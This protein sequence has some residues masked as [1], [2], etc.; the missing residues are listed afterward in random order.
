MTGSDP[1]KRPPYHHGDLHHALVQAGTELAR[2]GGP[3][4]IVLREAA[5]RVGV[6]PNAAYRHFSALPELIEAVAFD[7]LSALARSMEAEQAKCRPTGDAGRDAT[8]RL[9]A[10]G[11]GYVR[12]ALSEPGL[13]AV[14]FSPGKIAGDVSVHHSSDE[15]HGVGDS[16]LM[17]DELLEQALDGML[18]AGVLDAA[19][20]NTATLNAWAA[21]HGLSELLLGPMAGQTP[22]AQD[23]LI[24]AFLD[25]VGRG[26]ITR[27]TT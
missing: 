13:F 2:E 18:A 3:S 7:A 12:F 20:R 6:S 24:D 21:V 15:R 19:D 27:R 14:A 16:G 4:A 17:P 23:A 9:C 10:V 26:L 11:R 8:D 1:K 22:T 25:L 5:R